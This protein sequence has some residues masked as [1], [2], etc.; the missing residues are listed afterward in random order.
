VY[1]LHLAKH[2][3]FKVTARKIRVVSTV[4]VSSAPRKHTWQFATAHAQANTTARRMFSW[5]CVVFHGYPLYHSKNHLGNV[6]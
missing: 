2:H 6:D 4:S 3:P 1:Q 5:V